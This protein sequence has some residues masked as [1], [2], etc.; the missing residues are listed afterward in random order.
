[1][2][3]PYFGDN[4][5]SSPSFVE[6]RWRDSSSGGVYESETETIQDSDTRYSGADFTD[7]EYS[8]DN[9]TFSDDD[10]SP[11]A[12]VRDRPTASVDTQ[13]Y[14]ENLGANNE[15]MTERAGHR[16]KSRSTVRNKR[17]SYMR[18]P[19]HDF[20]EGLSDEN[21]ESI[22]SRSIS[23]KR[24]DPD[25]PAEPQPNRLS[26]A[27]QDRAPSRP[28]RASSPYLSAPRERSRTPLRASAPQLR[29]PYHFDERSC[30]MT[31]P[32]TES[33][34][35]ASRLHK[36]M[37]LDKPNDTRKKSTFLQ[38]WFNAVNALVG[39]GI[40]SMPLV[41]RQAGWLGGAILFLLCGF[42]TN[43][44]GKLIARIMAHDP[45][46]KTYVD[47]GRYAFGPSARYW[48]AVMFSAEMIFVSMALIILLGDSASVL[49]YGKDQEPDAWA[50]FAFKVIGF[51]LVLPT[52]FLPLSF[53]SPISLVGITS[54]LFTIIV[55]LID[56]FV[57][58]KTPGSLWDPADTELGPRFNGMGIGFG[59]LMSGFAS[60]PILPSLYRD[61]QHPEQF[62]R[63]LDLAYLT[64]AMLYGTMGAAGY[65]MFGMNV[66]DEMTSDLARTR[67][68]PLFLTTTCVVLIIVNSM[69]KFALALRPVQSFFESALG[70]SVDQ[71]SP[72]PVEE[73]ERLIPPGDSERERPPVPRI[74]G[75]HHI[76]SRLGVHMA[77]HALSVAVAVAVLCMALALPSLE[78]VMGFL[79]AFLTFNTC[80]VGP[81]LAAMVVFASER[82]FLSQVADLALLGITLVLAMLGTLYTLRPSL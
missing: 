32:D 8:A 53:L 34:Y 26:Y 22:R 79:G 13:T 80:I 60:H 38:T 77:R 10:T 7:G 45:Q 40:L 49:Y 66:S 17:P 78:R 11:G 81:I 5:I 57:K 20:D 4:L 36:P 55:L 50:L 75:L 48:I 54:I 18:P 37:A 28:P 64:T 74:P 69:S 2:P 41:L 46:L 1:M 47:I 67:G 72:A 24:I 43:Y 42:V 65:V 63:M 39:V 61:M 59:L 70:L 25:A 3:T 29:D 51:I 71:L 15:L 9:D 52:V 58:R 33:D 21:N 19:A 23:P 6:R 44:T 76:Y 56:G 62:N 12:R 27:A 73:Q 30:L 82:K 68:M 35:Q 31:M 14:W 16:S